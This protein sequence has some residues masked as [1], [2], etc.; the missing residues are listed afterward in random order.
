[1]VVATVACAI[2]AGGG[3]AMFGLEN[4]GLFVLLATSV[5]AALLI[6]R[7]WALVAVP[8]ATA[9]GG[10]LFFVLFRPEEPLLPGGFDVFSWN[11]FWAVAMAAPAFIGAVVGLWGRR[12]LTTWQSQRG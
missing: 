9:L 4:G 10:I 11:L 7:R 3:L 5:S 1:M 8:L 2:A 6:G 12:L